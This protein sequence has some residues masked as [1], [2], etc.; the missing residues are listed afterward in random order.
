MN[1]MLINVSRRK[2][3]GVYGFLRAICRCHPPLVLRLRVAAAHVSL[4]ILWIEPDR[5]LVI[6]DNAVVVAILLVRIRRR[7]DICAFSAFWRTTCTG[8]PT[9]AFRPMPPP[10]YYAGR[11]AAYPIAIA[12]GMV[13][14]LIV[15]HR[16]VYG[17]ANEQLCCERP[18]QAP[19]L[20]V[21]ADPRPVELFAMSGLGGS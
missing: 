6:G 7:R 17:S 16:R 15:I 13:V 3:R 5:L 14:A 4:G 8:I 2:L 10:C 12:A 11:L 1:L 20:L 18:R 19:H 9:G 21:T